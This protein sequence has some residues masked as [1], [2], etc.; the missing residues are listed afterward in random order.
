MT[1][2]IEDLQPQ[3]DQHRGELVGYCYR[4]LGLGVR[5]RGRGAGDHDARLAQPR[6]VRGPLGAALLALPDR[7]QRVPRHAQRPQAPGHADGPVGVV[8]AAGRGLARGP[9]ARG[10]SGSS[11]CSTARC[12]RPPATPPTLAVARDSIR[13]AFV[14][15][16]QHLPPRQR[17]VLILR[18]VLRWKADEVAELLET[19]GGLGQQRPAARPGHARHRPGSREPTPPARWTTTTASC[20]RA[21]SRR[22]RATTSTRFV[23]LLHEDA[24]QNMPPYEMWLQGRDDIGALDARPGRA[25]ARGRG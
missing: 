24:T 1:V 9:A 12:S 22:S 8:L 7:H 11:R 17:A 6:P 13:L 5:R 3:L 23:A 18:D 15:A 25:T 14:A 16:L 4:M 19:V 21:T 10:R 20:W 2:A